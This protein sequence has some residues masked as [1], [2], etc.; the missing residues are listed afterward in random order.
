MSNY[1]FSIGGQ[2]LVYALRVVGKV[3]KAIDRKVYDR[4]SLSTDAS[5]PV[6]ALVNPL[7]RDYR[8]SAPC[9]TRVLDAH[10]FI[11]WACSA[12]PGCPQGQKWL[13]R[14]PQGAKNSL[15]LCD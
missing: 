12:P 10:F 7:S 3:T 13:R 1:L 2:I 9:A 15:Y 4:S 5:A 6:A 8:S 11:V 14:L